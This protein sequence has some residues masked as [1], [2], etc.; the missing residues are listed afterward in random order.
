[1]VSHDAALA[2]AQLILLENIAH[3][4][5]AGIDCRTLLLG[6]GE[7]EPRFAALA[8][9]ACATDLRGCSASDATRAALRD[10]H[11]KGWTP[12]AA[13]CNTIAGVEAA[14]ALAR[15]GLPVLSSIYELPTSIDDNL[16]GQRAVERILRASKRV[17]VA[18]AFVRDRLAETYSIDPERLSPLHTGVLT[19]RMPSRDEARRE[20]R[21]ELGIGQDTLVVLGC[22]SVHHR[23][24]SDLFVAAAARATSELGPGRAVFVWVGDD[25]SGPTFRNWCRHDIERAGLT[26]VVRFVG[27]RPDPAP[28]FAGAD[29]FALTSREDPFPMVC[30]EALSAGLGVVAFEGAGG[31]TEVLHPDRG[32]AVP[33]ADAAAMGTAIAALIQDPPALDALR[34]RARD[35]ARAHLG[36]DRYTDQLRHMLAESCSPRFAQPAGVHAEP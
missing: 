30:L 7:L 24:G 4:T 5:R 35:F 15:T 6:P 18:S 13:F 3:W 16:G 32:I 23:K 11:A 9:T 36:W 22:G 19:R 27:K 34:Y 14:D 28:W 31:A 1:M 10:L 20:I 33:Y 29:I 8:P 25:Q 21:R 12:D 2:G 26:G 17:V